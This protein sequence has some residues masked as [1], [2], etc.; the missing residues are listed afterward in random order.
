MSAQ[1]LNCLNDAVSRNERAKYKVR[2]HKH[3]EAFVS[4]NL[5]ASPTLSNSKKRVPSQ[6]KNVNPLLTFYSTIGP[7]RTIDDS[8]PSKIDN[9]DLL[10]RHSSWKELKPIPSLVSQTRGKVRTARQ[11]SSEK[12]SQPRGTSSK[13]FRNSNILSSSRIPNQT[14]QRAS[15]RVLKI[16]TACPT[17]SI[18]SCNVTQQSLAPLASYI[19]A[20][21]VVNQSIVRTELQKIRQV[22]K[23][24]TELKKVDDDQYFERKRERHVNIQVKIPRIDIN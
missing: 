16:S 20:N 2:R 6:S 23:K 13:V 12:K 5:F 11:K 9:S 21:R 15:H 19:R 18:R 1:P 24:Q 7:L 14:S 8:G 4:N 3:F 17:D 22:S 10:S